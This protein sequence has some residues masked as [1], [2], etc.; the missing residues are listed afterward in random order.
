M[1]RFSWEGD[2]VLHIKKDKVRKLLVHCK[3]Y[4][5]YKD[6]IFMMRSNDERIT[7]GH[8]LCTGN[9]TLYA[10]GTFTVARM[11]DTIGVFATVDG[12]RF[13][14]FRDWSTTEMS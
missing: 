5:G 9:Y 7:P 12:R 1:N 13:K 2:D 10:E 8:L 14:V 6:I 11:G 4:N 3:S